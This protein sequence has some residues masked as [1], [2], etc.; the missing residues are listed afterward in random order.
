MIAAWERFWFEPES[1][2]PLAVLRIVLGVIV[3][4][5]T[6]SLAGDLDAFFSQTGLL[7]KGPGGGGTW[8]VLAVFPAD[9]AV[10]L[11]FAVLL[12]ACIALILGYQ[13]RLAALLVFV[14][15]LSLERRDP[16]VFNTG[17]GLIRLIAF[18]LMLAPAGVALSLDR[19]RFAPDRFWEFPKRAPWALRLM[20]IQLSIIYLAGLWVKLQ[21]T[22]WNDG[23]AVSY[24]MRISDLTRLPLPGFL[25]H[26]ALLSNLMTYGTLAIEFSVP[27]LVWNRRLRPWVMLAGI[28]LHLGIEYSIRVGFFSVAMLTLYLSFLDPAWAENRLLAVRGWLDRIRARST[29][30]QAAPA[31]LPEH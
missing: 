19:R 31:A 25:I 27:I 4:G 20:Q 23:T 16:Y 13:T 12:I 6:L 2:A 21:G 14:A 5:W 9:L 22:T 7:S 17:D 11:V 3:L 15:I 30:R 28:S 8:G 18:Y 10:Q 24:A 29:R 1:T 26:S